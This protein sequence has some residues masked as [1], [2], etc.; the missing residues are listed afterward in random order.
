MSTPSFTL[1]PVAPD[2]DRHPSRRNYGSN[3]SDRTFPRQEKAWVAMVREGSEQAFERIF[4]VYYPKLCAFVAGY[5]GSSEAAREIVQDVFLRIWERRESWNVRVTLR[6]YLYQSVR[7]RALDHLRHR[8]TTRAVEVP[9]AP[10]HL[11]VATPGGID[12]EVAYRQLVQDVRAAVQ[13]LPERRQTAFV[14]HR[15]HGLSYAEIGQVMDVSP[16]TVEVHISKALQH[17]REVLT[18]AFD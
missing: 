1:K 16:R 2:L 3:P 17:L 12:D 5:V 11:D 10:M 13:Q 8:R 4:T 18:D 6:A 14:L 15:Q 9:L 7:N